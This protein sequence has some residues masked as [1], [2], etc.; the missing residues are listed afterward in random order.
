M[1]QSIEIQVWN[2]ALGENKENFRKADYALAW[3]ML[4]HGQTMN[5][6]VFSGIELL[7]EIEY[8]EESLAGYRFF[9]LQEICDLFNRAKEVLDRNDDEEIDSL[10]A[11]MDREYAKIIP[12]DE[13]LFSVFEKYYKDHPHEFAP[14]PSNLIA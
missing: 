4:L 13:F 14:I 9:G 8:Y 7:Q 11:V 6:G 2:R 5:G 3:L 10:E 12:D 1:K